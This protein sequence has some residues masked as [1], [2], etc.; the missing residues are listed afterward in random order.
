MA[1]T[2]L[3][4]PIGKTPAADGGGPVPAGRFR[5]FGTDRA[6]PFAILIGGYGEKMNPFLF[7]GFT[8]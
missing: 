7:F 1:I 5:R 6:V 3:P 4:H 8:V 2:H